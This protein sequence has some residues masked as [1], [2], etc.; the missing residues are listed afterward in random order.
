MQL[1]QYTDYSLRVLIYLARKPEGVATIS[2][3]AEYHGI[4]RNHLVKVIHNLAG[5][6]F[7]NT[8]RGRSGGMALTR[9]PE[10][11]NMGDV[12]RNTEANFYIAECFNTAQN[13]C[14]ITR[15]CGLK[16]MFWE[17]Q[18]SFLNTLDQYTLADVVAG[19][20]ATR[21]SIVPIA[22]DGVKP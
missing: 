9:A 1:T 17:A 2:E 3:I 19:R 13:R 8:T 15:G 14:V 18:S 6:G 16:S 10:E 7:I 20:K 22:V 12:V 11:I 21:P 4:S 5:K